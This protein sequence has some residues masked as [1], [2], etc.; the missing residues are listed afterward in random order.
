MQARFKL[1][2]DTKYLQVQGNHG[3]VLTSLTTNQI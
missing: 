3:L 1:R 2:V